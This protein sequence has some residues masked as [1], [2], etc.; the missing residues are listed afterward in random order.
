MS[1]QRHLFASLSDMND[2]MKCEFDKHTNNIYTNHNN[3]NDYSIV[4]M[5][6]IK[7]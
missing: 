7:T 1:K 5:S 3:C 6:V 2:E 4:Y